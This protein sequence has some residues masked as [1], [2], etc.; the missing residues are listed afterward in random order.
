MD[1]APRPNVYLPLEKHQDIPAYCKDS[2][3][4]KWQD[5]KMSSLTCTTTHYIFD[6]VRKVKSIYIK[7]SFK[8]TAE[9]H[10][11]K[12]HTIFSLN[13]LHI[14]KVKDSLSPT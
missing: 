13:L 9:N 2:S 4:Y 1:H 6:T 5:E 10:G 11:E 7:C 3:K 8:F 12:K 14:N